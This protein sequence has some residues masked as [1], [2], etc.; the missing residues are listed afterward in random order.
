MFFIITTNPYLNHDKIYQ[1]NTRIPH[2]KHRYKILC[3]KKIPEPI[4]PEK[5]AV[6][7]LDHVDLDSDCFRLGS[8]KVLNHDVFFSLSSKY[9]IQ[10]YSKLA[11][12]C[13]VVL[14]LKSSSFLF[15]IF[16]I[17]FDFAWL[18]HIFGHFDCCFRC[19]FSCVVMNHASDDYHIFSSLCCFYL[20]TNFVQ[21]LI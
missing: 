11:L 16:V 10:K 3:I 5:A 18:Y 6:A 4:S 21:K 13:F 19:E 1:N 14:H 8:T 2:A 15:I 7:I 17:A 12:H 9:L 20:S